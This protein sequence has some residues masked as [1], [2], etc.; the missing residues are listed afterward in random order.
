MFNLRKVK[1]YSNAAL[2]DHIFF[3]KSV[4]IAAEAG[5]EFRF[6]AIRVIISFPIETG[7]PLREL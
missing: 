7:S 3:L 6:S 5:R 2:T 1:I 4:P